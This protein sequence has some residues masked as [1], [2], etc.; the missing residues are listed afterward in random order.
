MQF[1]K[2]ILQA[3]E[4][5]VVPEKRAGGL[6]LVVTEEFPLRV[7]LGQAERN[8]WNWKCRLL[9]CSEP[10][11]RIETEARVAV[12]TGAPCRL[13]LDLEGFELVVPC[14]VSNQ[15][16]QGERM[17]VGLK[18]AVADAGT[19]AA[20][21]Q[22]LEIIALGATLRLNVRRS[23]P[24]STEYLVE[25]YVSVR[26]SCLNVWRYPATAMVAGADFILRDC[27]VRVIAGR[28]LEYYAGIDASAAPRAAPDQ[29]LE[30]HRLFKWVVPNLSLS[31]PGDVRD[32]LLR[33]A[34]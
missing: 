27:L 17:F 12:V 16:R 3:P 9:N 30:L 13:M 19:Q 24:S 4:K 2:R 34:G 32:F 6:R 15:R 29:A 23:Q 11:L 7:G 25:Q 1:F 14:T 21:R 28:P 8:T 18:Q 26:R 33:H 20:Y 31:V 22:F 5:A 10:G